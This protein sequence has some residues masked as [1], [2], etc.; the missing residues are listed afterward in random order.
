MTSINFTAGNAAPNTREG[1]KY[2]LYCFILQQVMRMNV[3]T[4]LFLVCVVVISFEGLVHA[5]TVSY[6]TPGT[7]NFTVPA[8]VSS[9]TIQA[10]GG[11]GGNCPGIPRSGGFGATVTATISVTPGEIL[12]IVVGGA[13]SD[14]DGGFNGGAAGSTTTDITQGCAGGGGGASDVRQAGYA[15]INRVVIAGGGGGIGVAYPGNSSTAGG[16]AGT[17]PNG[18]GGA[19]EDIEAFAA[20]PAGTGTGGSGGGTEDGGLA[21]VGGANFDAR[22]GNG[23][24]GLGGIGTALVPPPSGRRGSVGSTVGGG[25]GGGG[26]YGGGAG[27]IYNNVPA[28]PDVPATAGGGAGSSYAVATATD[29]SIAVNS[30]AGANNG[31]VVLN[32]TPNAS[33]AGP[34]STSNSSPASSHKQHMLLISLFRSLYAML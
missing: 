28:S 34:S 16:N 17:Y 6:T 19:G 12:G 24:F 21:G 22:G 5:T 31:S 2:V 32:Y 10:V 3:R 30:Q 8:L 9:I 13:G 18:T 4:V 23:T 33:S 1:L 7:Y 27:S 26:Y 29:A 15:L 20:L 25:G 11:A 14:L